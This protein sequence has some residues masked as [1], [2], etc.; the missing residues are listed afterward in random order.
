MDRRIFLKT[1]SLMGATAVPAL[2]SSSKTIEKPKTEFNAVLIDTT[3]CEGCQSCEEACLETYGREGVEIGDYEA[4]VKRETSPDQL[5]LINYFEIDDEEYYIKN[6]CMHCNQPA[7]A[8]ACLT[9]AMVKTK[10]GPVIWNA[11][12][13]MGCRFCMVS[14]PFN[15]PKFEYSKANPDVKKCTMCYE[16][17]QEGELPAC[18]DACPNEAI[19]YGTRRELIEE[20]KRRIYQSPDEYYHHIYGENEVGGTSVLYLSSIPFENIGLKTDVGEEALPL[21]T[22]DFLYGVPVIET[23]LPPLLLGISAAAGFR[24]KRME[25]N[26]DE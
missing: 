2:A 21:A 6:Q 26:D 13:C 8:S 12:K 1:M 7:C 20:A 11:D 10:E 19:V 25:E 15:I 3:L 18:V 5:T 9:N 22:T 23:L 14:C 4:N 16:R 24:K 17:T